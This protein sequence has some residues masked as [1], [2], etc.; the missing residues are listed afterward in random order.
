MVYSKLQPALVSSSWIINQ[1]TSSE[2]KNLFD[3]TL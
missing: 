3:F 1:N 2:W